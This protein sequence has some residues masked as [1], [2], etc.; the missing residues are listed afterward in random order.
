MDSTITVPEKALGSFIE[1][2]EAKGHKV[3]AIGQA[4][5]PDQVVI[6]YR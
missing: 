4:T 6:F 2:L 3:M 1:A 5:D